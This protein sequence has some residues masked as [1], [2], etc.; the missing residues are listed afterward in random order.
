MR[1]WT[2]QPLTIL[3]DCKLASGIVTIGGQD[4]AADSSWDDVEFVL[5]SRLTAPLQ[6]THPLPTQCR[7]PAGPL[8][9]LLIGKQMLALSSVPLHCP[10]PIFSS[11]SWV[12]DASSRAVRRRFPYRIVYSR[13]ICRV[14]Q[15]PMRSNSWRREDAV[16]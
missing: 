5:S 11:P 1:K 4:S 10:F 2:L 12:A 8:P 7:Q 14:L 6:L 9:E 3:F 15:S 16:R 13:E